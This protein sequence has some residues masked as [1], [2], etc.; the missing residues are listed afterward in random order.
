[1][2]QQSNQAVDW[3]IKESLMLALETI[4]IHFWRLT[5]LEHQMEELMQTHILPELYSEHEFMRTRACQTYFA[6]L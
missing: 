3:R 1:M 5:N 4:S 2:K 6:Y